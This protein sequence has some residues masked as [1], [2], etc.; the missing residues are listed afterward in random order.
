MEEARG[1]PPEDEEWP[2][3]DADTLSV[4]IPNDIL[5]TLLQE[6][7]KEN[8][9][10]NRGYILDGYPRTYDDA[11]EC[12]LELPIQYDEEGEPIEPEEP[13]LEEGEKK[14]FSKHVPDMKIFPKSCILLTGSNTELI[15]RVKE[16]SEE[17]ITGTHYNAKDMQ[18]RLMAYRTANNSEVAE[19]SVH[20]FFEE[21]EM[22]IFTESMSTAVSEA[23]DSFEIYIEREE[24]PY[25]YMTWDAEEEVKRQA[26]VGEAVSEVEEKKICRSLQEENLEKIL[27]VQK[28]L[29][30]KQNLNALQSQLKDSIDAKSQPI[31]QYLMDNLVP[32]L[33]DGL[34]DVCKNQPAD[35][36]DFLAEYLFKRSLDVPYPDPTTY[37]VNKAPKF[38]NFIYIMFTQINIFQIVSFFHIISTFKR[39]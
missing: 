17:E 37:W 19:P 7:L 35:V 11:N 16:L 3:I 22:Q 9:C 1:D 2:E 33:T 12:F 8:A 38:Y 14:D 25:N 10:R 30:I 6:K 34:I 28:E 13:E 29:A 27:K 32:I 21:K 36:C 4:R 39:L 5:Y 20:R 18:R 24:R 26:A 31:R 15:D 23:F